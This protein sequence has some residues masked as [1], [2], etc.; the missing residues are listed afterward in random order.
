MLVAI[1]W[2]EIKLVERA[3]AGWYMRTKHCLAI[4]EGKMETAAAHYE[5]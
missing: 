3:L 5:W 1:D 4:I 2:Y